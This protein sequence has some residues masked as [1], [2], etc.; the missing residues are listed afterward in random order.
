MLPY[1]QP[2][3]IEGSATPYVIKKRVACSNAKAV[4]NNYETQ[5]IYVTVHHICG[6]I[7]TNQLLSISQSH[8]AY[9]SSIIGTL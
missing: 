2:P 7:Q 1:P 9:F 8:R 5:H 3:E 6:C 4:F